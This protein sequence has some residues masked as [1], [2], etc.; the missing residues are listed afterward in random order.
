MCKLNCTRIGFFSKLL[1]LQINL[2]I[3]QFEKT[4]AASMK[5]SILRI[6]QGITQTLLT[7]ECKAWTIVNI[8]FLT[9][10]PEEWRQ[11]KSCVFATNKHMLHLSFCN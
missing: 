11:P 7:F 2:A 4:Q 10:D 1:Y 6:T 9:P 3:I 5:D 8:A